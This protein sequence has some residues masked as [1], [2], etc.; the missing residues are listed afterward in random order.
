MRPGLRYVHSTG[1]FPKGATFDASWRHATGRT[2]VIVDEHMYDKPAWFIQNADRYDSYPRRGATIMVGEWAA[3]PGGASIARIGRPNTWASAVAEAAFMTGIERNV[4][5]VEM[6]CYAPL[7]ALH[8]AKQWNHNLIDFTPLTVLRTL[9]YE[10][11]KLFAEAVGDVGLAVRVTGGDG[12][13]A[14]ATGSTDSAFVKLVN[15]SKQPATVTVELDIDETFTA[16]L[17]LLTAPPRSR[18]EI[19][20]AEHTGTPL[21]RTERDLGLVPRRFTVELPAWSVARIDPAKAAE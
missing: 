10:V 3:N 19:L 5:L 4:D 13:L 9:N 7:L 1:A 11:Q 12:V 14:S 20:D 6:T 15:P 8:N 17:L 2:D 16:R 18:A 21:S